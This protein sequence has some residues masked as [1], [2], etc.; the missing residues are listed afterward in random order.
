[1]KTRAWCTIAPPTHL[2]TNVASKACFLNGAL[3]WLVE[4]YN[5]ELTAVHS[6]YI[7]TFDL[8]THIFGMIALPEPDMKKR[9]LTT[10]QGCL[11][12]ISN[13]HHDDTWIWVRRDASWFVVFRSERN[14][15][16]GRL[17]RVLQSTSNGDLLAKTCLGEAHVYNP[18]MGVQSRIVNFNSASLICD[19]EMCVENLELL[20]L[21]TTC[22]VNQLSFHGDKK[23]KQKK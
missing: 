7:L 23:E 2:Y 11:A 1:M 10:I 14:K 17:K 5:A 16:Q 8:S 20:D 22:E 15:V 18:K 3:H 13:M 12:V 19:M 6:R 21:A 4:R 9:Q